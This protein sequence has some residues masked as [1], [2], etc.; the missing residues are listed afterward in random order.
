MNKLRLKLLKFSNSSFFPYL[1]LI[2]IICGIYYK[3]F[4]FGKIPF[5]GDLLVVSYSPW[6]DYYKFPVQNP[7]ISDVFS[8]QFLWKYLSIDIFKSL[9]WPLWNPFSFTGNSLLATYQSATLYPL[10]ILLLLP[11][12]FGWG[13]FIFSQTLFATL[14]MYLLLSEWLPSKLARLTG[15]ILFALS[16]LMTTWLEIGTAVHAIIW[17]PFSLYFILRYWKSFK[18]RYLLLLIAS[19]TLLILA[20]HVQITTYSLITILI[21]ALI[22]SWNKNLKKFFIQFFPIFISIILGLLICSP[23][24]LSSLDLLNKSIRI[25]ESYTKE[26]NFGLLPAKEILKT[27]IPDFFGNPVTRNYWGFLNYPETSGFIGSLTLILL[28]YSFIYLKKNKL[29]IFFLSLLIISLIFAF[30]NIISYSIYILKIPL[31]TSSYASRMLFITGFAVAILSA[32]AIDH[33][34]NGQ[35]S[36]KKI[37]K[38]AIWSWATFVGILLGTLLTRQVIVNI[39]QSVSGKTHLKP[40]LEFYLHD[41]DYALYNFV[42]AM[43]NSLLP[44]FLVTGFIIFLLV[45]KKVQLR[46][47]RNNNLSIICFVIFILI[48][49][50]LGRYF[51]KFNPFVSQKLVYP[52]TPTLTYLKNQPGFFRI[53]REHAE[54]LPP[55]TWIAYNL[56]SFEGYDPI[57]LNNYAKFMNFLNGGD[58][59]KSSTG[60]YAELAST[61]AS[62]YLDSANIK[63]FIAILRDKNGYIPGELLNFKFNEAKYNIVFKDRSS[64]ILE[65]PNALERVYF[66]KNIQIAS[67]TQTENIFMTDKKFDPRV[68]TL[69]AKNLNINQVSGT[70]SAIITKYTPNKVIIKTNTSQNEV[71]VLSDQYEEGWKA[72]IDGQ[73]TTISP[74]NYVFRAIKV[75]SGSH[76]IIFTYW[77]TSFALGLKLTLATIGFILL[78]SIFAIKNQSF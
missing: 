72:K 15:S 49:L 23:Q 18:F 50:D 73:E 6:F 7:I 17:L 31:L 41:P 59:R 43:R 62:P 25:T 3:F 60:R 2:S 75:P 48:T 71:L 56:S 51:L 46:F 20:G 22:F 47:I 10:N 14:G 32:F 33:I 54:V 12:Y 68:T 24:L 44:I 57:Y 4:L 66:A 26:F 8:Q 67:L 65:N 30:D 40:V 37:L 9:H 36:E 58:I 35:E 45:I 34:I 55:N 69:L 19:L 11:K 29:T 74:A 76:E 5:P 42:V 64:A 38:L 16:S 13:V 52:P 39:I 78:L 77:P 27:F 63:Y 61:Y 70:G 21:F 53:G 1:I 28:L